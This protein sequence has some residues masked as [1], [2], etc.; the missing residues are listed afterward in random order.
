MILKA[1]KKII[2]VFYHSFIIVHP[3]AIM[4]SIA[5]TYLHT[6]VDFKVNSDLYLNITSSVGIL[7]AFVILAV[8][9]INFKSLICDYNEWVYIN[10]FSK[11]QVQFGQK[12]TNTLF[13]LI[14]FNVFI[15]AIQY[16]LLVFGYESVFLIF[17]SISYLVISFLVIVAIWHGLEIDV[18]L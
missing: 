1:V 18:K 17:L 2:M 3:I 4:T 11:I 14:T 10:F 5:L 7:T 15:L 6:K 9:K 13:T 8:D 16:V 12:V